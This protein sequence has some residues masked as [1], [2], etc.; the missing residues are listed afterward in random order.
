MYIYVLNEHPV[1][2]ALGSKTMCYFCGSSVFWKLGYHQSLLDRL[3]SLSGAKIVAHKPK[4]GYR[5][6]SHKS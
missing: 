3:S 1:F 6:K 5:F 4:F 2:M